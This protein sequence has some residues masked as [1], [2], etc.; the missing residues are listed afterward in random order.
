MTDEIQKDLL[1]QAKKLLTSSDFENAAKSARGVLALD[2][3]N[4][5]ATAILKAAEAALT[6]GNLS[7]RSDQD[8]SSQSPTEQDELKSIAARVQTLVD[9][10]K[11]TIILS[12]RE[13][14]NKLFSASSLLENFLVKHPENANAKQIL[15]DVHKAHRDANAAIER[16]RKGRNTF[17]NRSKLST[18]EYKFGKLD[19]E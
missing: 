18:N 12:P 8:S 19:R 1:T 11:A 9:S 10:A 6:G 7:T 15:N 3:G 16:N 17:L 14:A 2:E 4:S 13:T 5:E